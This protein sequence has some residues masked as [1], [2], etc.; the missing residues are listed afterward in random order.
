MSRVVTFHETGGPEVLR[1]E[2]T[3]VGAPGPGQ[4]RVRHAAVGLNFADTYFRSGLYPVP[5]PSGL[6]NEASGWVDAVGP[7]V[8]SLAVGDRAAYAG[9]TNT[10]FSYPHLTLPKT[11]RL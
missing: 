1:V 3:E 11:F 5:L 2:N 10:L 6:G 9:F 8:T 7:G 4:V